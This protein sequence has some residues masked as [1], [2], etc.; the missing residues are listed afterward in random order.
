MVEYYGSSRSMGGHKISLENTI[1]E[2]GKRTVGL[3]RAQGGGVGCSTLL[4]C[5]EQK[6][7]N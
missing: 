7:Q 6:R 2:G 4:D 1:G 5:Y 3:I